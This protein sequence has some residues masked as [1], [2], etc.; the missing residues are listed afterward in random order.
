MNIEQY[1]WQGQISKTQY[2]LTVFRGIFS[3][4]FMENV[5]RFILG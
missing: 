5:F 1:L 4:N 2:S 3:I